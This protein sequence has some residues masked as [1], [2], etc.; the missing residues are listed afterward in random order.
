MKRSN[1][2]KPQVQPSSGCSCVRGVTATN[3]LIHSLF[4]FIPARRHGQWPQSNYTRFAQSLRWT[5]SSDTTTAASNSLA[6]NNRR[7]VSF[8]VGAKCRA[9]PVQPA[10][11]GHTQPSSRATPGARVCGLDPLLAIIDTGTRSERA[12]SGGRVQDERVYVVVLT[13]ATAMQTGCHRRCLALEQRRFDGASKDVLDLLLRHTPP[14]LRVDVPDANQGCQR[15]VPVHAAT[16]VTV[17]SKTKA[18]DTKDVCT[19]AGG[20]HNR[21]MR[22]ALDTRAVDL[23][24]LWTNSSTQ[25]VSGVRGKGGARK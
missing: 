20:G 3:G 12:A 15:C 25:T 1:R 10:Q 7:R 16:K 11:H 18:N 24:A 9:M 6:A 8:A 4:R 21:R 22:A 19:T 23:C 13:R 5:T 2:T 17:P 14:R